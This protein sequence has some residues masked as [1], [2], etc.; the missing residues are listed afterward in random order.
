MD[1]KDEKFFIALAYTA[2]T[3]KDLDILTFSQKVEENQKILSEQQPGK[4]HVCNK[5]NYPGL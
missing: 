5:S 1:R 4:A 2:A 3:E